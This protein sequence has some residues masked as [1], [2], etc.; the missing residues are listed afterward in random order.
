MI[1]GL[2]HFVLFAGIGLS[3]FAILWFA[4]RMRQTRGRAYASAS[5]GFCASCFVFAMLALIT[6]FV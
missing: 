1:S 4:H 6:R 2:L 5:L 3:L